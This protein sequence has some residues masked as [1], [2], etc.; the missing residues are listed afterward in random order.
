MTPEVVLLPLGAEQT[1]RVAGA[2]PGTAPDW[3]VSNGHVAS[4][5]SAGTVTALGVGTA[6]V[7]AGMGEREATAELTV[8]AAFVAPAAGAGFT[9]AVTDLGA[10][11]CWGRDWSGQLGAGEPVR[12]SKQ[13][14]RARGV[15]GRI[16]FAAIDAGVSH[17]CG[18]DQGGQAF[19]WGSSYSG[20]RG[21]GRASEFDEV[22]RPTAV[23]DLAFS[24]INVGEG[25]SCA[26]TREGAA[27]CW[28]AASAGQIGGPV[29]TICTDRYGQSRGSCAFGP[30]PVSGG[31]S[32][33]AISAGSRHTCAVTVVGDA[34]CWGSDTR[35]ELGLGAGWRPS[36]PAGRREPALVVGATRF[37]GIAAGDAHTCALGTDARAWCWGAN[38]AGQLGTGTADTLVHAT[39]QP[40]SGELR[41]GSISAGGS[42]TCAVTVDGVAYCWGD[43]RSGQLGDGRGLSSAVPS[44]VAGTLRAATISAGRSHTC[45][46][47]D[48]LLYCWGS[49]TAGELGTGLDT[50][51]SVPARVFGQ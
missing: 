1:L 29:A 2:A 23:S 45:A 21:T 6:L 44:R 9:C 33:R 8:R 34:Y 37:T 27:Y 30:T 38:A 47:T 25:H 36:A 10:A 19:C 5:N 22:S 4:V 18:L 51:S 13:W 7:R 49:G 12:N 41:F 26:L 42:H 20:E 3:G 39:P 32:F 35:G 50:G 11:G 40:V 48:R 14:P 16:R 46:S 17:A 43:N 15:V 24:S 31:L 28:G